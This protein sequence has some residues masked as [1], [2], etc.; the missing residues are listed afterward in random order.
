MGSKKSEFKGLIQVAEDGKIL[1]FNTDK[2]VSFLKDHKGERFEFVIKK[3]RSHQQLKYYWVLVG[4]VADYLGYSSEEMH[5]IVKAKF[6][7]IEYVHEDTGEIFNRVKSTKELSKFEMSELT[8]NFKMWAA[9]TFS[10]ALPDPDQQQQIE[11]NT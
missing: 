4:I 2:L 6:L 8:N 5:E 7:T 11:Y 10:I 9:Q 3:Y 1:W